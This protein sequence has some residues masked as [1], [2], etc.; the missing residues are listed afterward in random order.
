MASA[1]SARG[2]ALHGDFVARAHNQPQGPSRVSGCALLCALI[3]ILLGLQRDGSILHQFPSALPDGSAETRS[4]SNY[5]T[6]RANGCL[7]N[8]ALGFA[9]ILDCIFN[10]ALSTYFVLDMMCWKANPL[11]DTDTEFRSVARLLR[12]ATFCIGVL[13]CVALLTVVWHVGA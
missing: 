7:L 11:Y 5:C 13:T 12:S 8:D 4:S 3:C 1:A 2:H 6:L 9:G 10:K